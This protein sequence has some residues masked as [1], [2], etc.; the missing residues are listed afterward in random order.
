[1]PRNI[2]GRK[3]TNTLINNVTYWRLRRR[4]KDTI[5]VDDGCAIATLWFVVCF[6]LHFPCCSRCVELWLLRRFHSI[7][8][9]KLAAKTIPNTEVELSVHFFETILFRFVRQHCWTFFGHSWQKLVWVH[10]GNIITFIL[11]FE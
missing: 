11:M 6:V 3:Q 8:L 2:V 10:W 5:G 4:G 7:E 9:A 1:M